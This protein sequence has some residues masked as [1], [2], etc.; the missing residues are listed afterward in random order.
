M[1]REGEIG[2]EFTA[3][4]EDEES[5]YA[6]GDFAL[7]GCCLRGE[8]GMKKRE[9]IPNETIKQP[10]KTQHPPNRRIAPQTPPA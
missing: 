1:D 8:G 10:D 7:V 3:G 5:N 6:S 4:Y 9:S 2:D